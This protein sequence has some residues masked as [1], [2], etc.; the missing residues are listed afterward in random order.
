MN[1]MLDINSSSRVL[2]PDETPAASSG[3]VTS[4]RKV[5]DALKLIPIRS[6]LSYAGALLQGVAGVFALLYLLGAVALGAALL[7]YTLVR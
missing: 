3:E 2:T 5:I 7:F 6:S 4:E 1:G